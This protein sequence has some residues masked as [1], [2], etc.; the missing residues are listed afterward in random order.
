LAIATAAAFHTVLLGSF[1]QVRADI[2]DDFKSFAL[3]AE[4]S[5]SYWYHVNRFKLR[6]DYYEG[7]T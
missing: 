6:Y 2:G 7:R 1:S 4:F 5:E 3:I